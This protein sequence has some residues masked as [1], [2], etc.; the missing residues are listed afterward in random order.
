M[1]AVPH[2]LR[3]PVS[4]TLRREAAALTV[5]GLAA[6]L[7]S[8]A[9]ASASA[10]DYAALRSAAV[11]HCQAIDANAYHTGL[12]FNP[13][14]YHSMYTRSECLQKA[15]IE[16]RD[17]SLC[18]QVRQRRSLFFSSWGI[19]PGRCRKL[20][21]EGIATDRAALE[22]MKRLYAG[23]AVKVQSFRVE[24]DGNGRDFDF[25]PVFSGDYPHGYTLTFEILQ[26]GA[27]RST[28]L[29]HSSGYYLDAKPN[30]RI[31]VRQADIR[32]RFP[33]FQLNHP[34][35]VRATLVLAVGF[36]GPSGYWSDTFIEG[37]FPARERSQSLTRE[38][39]FR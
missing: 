3:E 26:A 10:A 27:A 7:F 9:I 33:G 28:I 23:H 16:F 17:A 36:G 32:H 15:A 19:A 8:F 21:S 24:R 2:S 13:D 30:L 34:Y 37:V 5:Q 18:D 38:I 12:I 1:Q 22:K 25:I 35:E 39:A 14:G 6:V 31:Y 29:L 20:V 4:C 11:S